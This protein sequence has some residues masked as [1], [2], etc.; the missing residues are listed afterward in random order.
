MGIERVHRAAPIGWGSCC[1][2]GQEKASVRNVIMLK[3]RSPIP[4]RGWGCVV[5]KVPRDGAVAVV[6]DRC[7]RK[8]DGEPVDIWLRWACRGYPATDGRIP[9]AELEGEFDHDMSL[10]PEVEQGG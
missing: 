2:C 6:C 8:H 4:G 7:M 10:H 3:N 1:C 9:F 5:C